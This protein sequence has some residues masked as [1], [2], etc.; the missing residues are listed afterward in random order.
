MPDDATPIVARS[1]PTDP[2]LER[3]VLDEARTDP[4][5]RAY[6]IGPQQAGDPGRAAFYVPVALGGIRVGTLA[7]MRVRGEPFARSERDRSCGWP[8]SPR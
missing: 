1:G 3:R 6:V 4:G 5:M 7:A 8:T 2:E